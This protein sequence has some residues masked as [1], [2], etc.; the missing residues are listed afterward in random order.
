M[1]IGPVAWF[2]RIALAA[3]F[4]SAVADRFGWWPVDQ[5]VWGTWAAFVEYTQ[6]INPWLPAAVIP[7]VATLAT[8]LEVL[9]AIG[10]LVGRRL[11]L[12]A[13][14]SGGLLLL[15]GIAMAL[16]AGVKAPLDFSVFSA[17][18]GA[19]AL[20]ILTDERHPE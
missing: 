19:F 1:K 9:L 2:L 5:S 12:V 17:A 4:L 6:V 15:F 10:L 18:A 14:A 13:A 20:A 7:A 8:A 16:S 3:G 11:P